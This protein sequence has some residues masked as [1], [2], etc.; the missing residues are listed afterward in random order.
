MLMRAMVSTLLLTVMT[1]CTVAAQQPLFETTRIGEGVYQFRYQ[2]HNAFFVATADGVVAVDPISPEAAGP[3][4]EA[5]QR[6]APGQPLR[7]IVY[8]HH[9]AD[10]AGGAQVLRQAFSAAVPIIAHEAARARLVEAANPDVPPPTVTFSEQMTLHFGG[11][12]LELHHLGRNHS[13]N[14]VVALLPDDRIAFAVDFVSH[15][16][17]GYRELPDYYF[18]DF[19]ES[20]R[21]LRDL[22]FDTIVFG[23]GPA[24]DKSSIERQIA[25]YEALRAAVEE[26]VR[27]GQTEDEAAA[28]VQLPDFS[29]WGRY[30]EW[31]AMN[32][33]AVY[34]WVAGQAGQQ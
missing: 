1:V 26:A 29:H 15:D 32:V 25:Y 34:R 3:L 23:H 16:R 14:S 27:A 17:V 13:D 7:A 8:S 30:D 2:G 11:R 20:L 28:S 18:P 22:P 4:A 31:F 33:R 19:F 5:I 6:E 9:H 24:G 12:T 21:R 10:H